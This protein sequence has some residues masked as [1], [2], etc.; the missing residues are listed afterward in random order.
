VLSLVALVLLAALRIFPWITFNSQPQLH[1]MKATAANDLHYTE[2]YDNGQRLSS[3]GFLMVE[4]DDFTGA[5]DIFLQRLS[6][7]PN[8]LHVLN[9][10][11][12]VEFKLG[13]FEAAHKHCLQ[14]LIYKPTDPDFRYRAMYTAFRAGNIEKV[15]ELGANSPA[16][17]WKGEHV[18]RLYAGVLASQG[19]HEEAIAEAKQVQT[20]DIDGYLPWLLSHS[21]AIV[22]DTLYAKQMAF[23]AVELD[24]LDQRYRLWYDSLTVLDNP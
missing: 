16:G 1:Y 23:S 18:R 15:I 8:D 20:D 4:M 2:H 10:L 9:M 3:W 19:K 11:V 24:S 5:R 7:K 22:G 21:A 14:A 17:F 12:R 6:Y 13:E